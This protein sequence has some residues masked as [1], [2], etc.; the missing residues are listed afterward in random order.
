MWPGVVEMPVS[1][2][3]FGS[4]KFFTEHDIE[5]TND[6]DVL[7]EIEPVRYELLVDKFAK[8]ARTSSDRKVLAS[9]SIFR[10]Q[11]GR[12]E[13]ARMQKMLSYSYEKSLHLSQLRGVI[14]VH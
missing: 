2:Y 4:F 7:V 1:D 13:L 3:G 6:G 8:K 12:E 9:A 14:K 10:F 5:D 11:E